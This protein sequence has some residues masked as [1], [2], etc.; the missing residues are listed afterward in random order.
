M[1][2]LLKQLN[3]LPIRLF[4]LKLFL[5]VR[6]PS[7]REGVSLEVGAT[8]FDP[9]GLSVPSETHA[10]FHVVF[11]LFKSHGIWGSDRKRFRNVT[12]IVIGE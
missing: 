2:V 9:L 6:L 3:V 12:I 10:F 1:K 7:W 5:S 8:P 4:I 11:A